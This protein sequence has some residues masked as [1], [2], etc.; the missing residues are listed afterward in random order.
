MTWDTEFAPNPHYGVLTLATCKPT[1]R[2]CAK[3]EDWISG[4]AAR[5]VHDRN[6]VAHPFKEGQYLI[7]LAKISKIISF[8]DYWHNYEQKKP[9]IIT[10]EITIR[11]ANTCGTRCSRK[12]LQFDAGDNI[13][14]P[15]GNDVYKQ[16]ENGYHGAGD[17]NHD[18]S[19]KNVLICDEFYYFG[20]N[21]A[22]KIEYDVFPYVVPRCKKIALD[23]PSDFINYIK[24]KYVIGINNGL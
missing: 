15:K 22:I 4:W 21:N 16:H 6:G 14:E 23:K 10:R 9:Q 7:Y 12:I 17:T 13:Y 20:V 2:R 1:I 3:V 5:T 18:L 11:S 8:D 24:E 19:G